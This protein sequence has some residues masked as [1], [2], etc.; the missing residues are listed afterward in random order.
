MRLPFDGCKGRRSEGDG[1]T[2]RRADSFMERP[3]GSFLRIATDVSGLS[4]N[5]VLRFAFL[6]AFPSPGRREGVRVWA[7]A[8]E[9][10][11]SSGSGKPSDESVAGL[12]RYRQRQ[13]PFLGALSHCMASRAG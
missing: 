6:M 2:K 10:L 8:R 12:A 4:E 5:I 3:G 9:D 7:T 13:C 1:E 11:P